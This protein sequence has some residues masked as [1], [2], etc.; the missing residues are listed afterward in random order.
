MEQGEERPEDIRNEKSLGA[1][2]ISGCA[3][4]GLTMKRL[5]EKNR[6]RSMMKAD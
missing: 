6:M 1:S 5:I 2:C 3:A 4:I